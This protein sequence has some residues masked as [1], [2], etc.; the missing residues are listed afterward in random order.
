MAQESSLHGT[1][2]HPYGTGKQSSWH[3]KAAP[4]AQENSL[5]GKEGI[6]MAQEDCPRGIGKQS[7]WHRRASLW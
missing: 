5:H 1:E 4:V 6:P 3:R 7:S 2:G